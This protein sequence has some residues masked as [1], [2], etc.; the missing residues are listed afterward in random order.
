[1][2]SCF[3]DTIDLRSTFEYWKLIIH[4]SHLLRC[5]F[6]FFSLCSG[7]W[8]ESTTCLVPNFCYPFKRCK[9]AISYFCWHWRACIM[10]RTQIITRQLGFPS[11]SFF[12]LVTVILCYTNLVHFAHEHVHLSWFISAWKML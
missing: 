12:P 5:F 6:F 10:V 1:M 3:V 9:I 8:S 4:W 7:N 11:F 2:V